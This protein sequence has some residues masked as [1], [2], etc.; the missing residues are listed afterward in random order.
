M[1]DTRV[2]S[3][4]GVP[5]LAD[6]VAGVGGRAVRFAHVPDVCAQVRVCPL[7]SA[8]STSGAPPPTPLEIQPP[9]PAPA[10]RP[11]EP[12]LGS[13]AAARVSSQLP[14]SDSVSLGICGLLGA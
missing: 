8:G 14:P 2:R 7:R 4:P 10:G 11:P 1:C 3:L 12:V 5:L 6:R 13:R 9:T